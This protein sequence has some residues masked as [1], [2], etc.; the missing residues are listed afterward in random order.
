V[1]RDAGVSVGEIIH[2]VEHL[3]VAKDEHGNWSIPSMTQ[4]MRSAL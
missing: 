1:G 3:T 4:A 2:G